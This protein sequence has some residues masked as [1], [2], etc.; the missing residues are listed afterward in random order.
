MSTLEHKSK[1]SY[2]YSH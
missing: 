1:T 2:R